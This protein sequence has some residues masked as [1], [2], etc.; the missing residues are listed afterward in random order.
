M[1]Q[2]VKKPSYQVLRHRFYPSM[3]WRN[4]RGSTLEIARDPPTGEE[5]AW[6]LSLA[7]IEQDGAFSE[8]A[9]Y[10]R[11]LVLIA[12]KSLHL[13]FKGHGHC[14]LEAAGRGTRFEGDWKTHCAVPDG[15]CTDLSLIVQRGRARRPAPVVR[16]PSLLRL[17]PTCRLVLFGDLYAALFALDRP[18]AITDSAGGRSHTVRAQDTLLV[19]PGPGR[20]LTLRSLGRSSTAQVV[21]LQWRPGR[22]HHRSSSRRS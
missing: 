11:A 8:Y 18:V 5:F 10:R 13:R 21:L 14:I 1:I 9:G 4:G 6:R 7:D 17:K 3:P 22:P 20:V 2:D 16:A 12:G 19:S 15:R